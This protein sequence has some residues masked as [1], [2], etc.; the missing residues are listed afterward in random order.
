MAY[1]LISLA[2]P[3]PGGKPYAKVLLDDGGASIEGMR[4]SASDEEAKGELG[5]EQK[6]A[7]V[8]EQKAI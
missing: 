4:E 5:T 2:S 6:G 1:Y 7:I 3:L 8:E